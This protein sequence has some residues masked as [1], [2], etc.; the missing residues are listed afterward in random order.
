VRGNGTLEIHEVLKNGSA[1][2]QWAGTVPIILV[3]AALVV[4]K[5]GDAQGVRARLL[6]RRTTFSTDS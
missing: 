6:A 1:P 3:F 5:P 4:F 2:V